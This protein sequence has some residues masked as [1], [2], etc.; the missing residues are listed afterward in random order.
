[1]NLN[2]TEKKLTEPH[3]FTK[4]TTMKTDNE[5]NRKATK[6]IFLVLTA[7]ALC[8]FGYLKSKAQ[9]P[10]TYLAGASEGTE[11]PEF[12]TTQDTSVLDSFI[13]VYLDADIDLI[14]ICNTRKS[15]VYIETAKTSLYLVSGITRTNKRGK[16]KFIAT[17]P[18]RGGKVDNLTKH[19]KKRK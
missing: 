2:N 15:Y 8:L 6:F 13:S 9:E 1:M 16:E 17:V 14:K 19:N 12:I 10:I 18:Y 4:Y 11:Y 3:R 5:T 7:F